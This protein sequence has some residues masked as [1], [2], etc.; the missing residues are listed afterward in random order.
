MRF[1]PKSS[2]E[3]N[4]SDLFKAG[5]Y[6]FEIASAD[7]ATSKAGNE[8]IKLR[9]KIYDDAGKSVS[10]FDY[11]MESAMWKL[12]NACKAVGL[13]AEYDSGD[14]DPSDFVGKT[15][16]CKVV[17]EK[18]EQYGDQ[19]KI[20]DY[21]PPEKSTPGRGAKP[22]PK[23]AMAGIDDDIPFAACWQV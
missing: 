16:R 13:D 14:L 8:M 6:E 20:R 10:V 12:H 2:E 23:P 21:L 19:N 18:N 17:V 1:T 9:V 22:S 4:T 5:D 15:G 3:L 11:L 7:A